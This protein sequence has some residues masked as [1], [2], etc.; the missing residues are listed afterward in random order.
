MF[1]KIV[2]FFCFILQHLEYKL[3]IA[4]FSTGIIAL[5]SNYLVLVLPLLQKRMID[6]ITVSVFDIKIVVLL[7]L[8]GLFGVIISISEIII[9]NNLDISL[10]T[11]LQKDLLESA[12]RNNNKIIQAR[13]AGAY[14]V[15]VFGDSEQIGSLL[16]T[17]Y[18][19]I[20]LLCIVSVITL[21][22]TA[23]WT[24]VF[25]WVVIPTYIIML[26]ILYISNKIYKEKFKQVREMIFKLNPMVL[27]YLENKKT[28]LGY[29][30]ISNY[31][32]QL[33]S[34]FEIRNK[35]IKSAARANTFGR[36]ALE[37]T[38]TISMIIFF[39]LSMQEILNNRMELSSFIAMIAYFPIVFSPIIA[40]QNISAGMNR[41]NTLHE[42]IKD[43]LGGDL[44]F[45]IPQQST[46]QLKN[47]TFSYIDNETS[48]NN[49]MNNFSLDVNKK[50][51][52]VGVSGEGKTTIIKILTGEFEAN[53]GCCLLGGEQVQNIPKSLIYSYIRIYG[54][55][56]EIFDN[57]LEYNITLGKKSLTK[58]EYIKKKIS[59]VESIENCFSKMI[60]SKKLILDNM[61]KDILKNLFLLNDKD[62]KN[63][64]VLI[65]IQEE[66]KRY[67][68]NSIE[69]LASIL[70]SKNH[71]IQ[72]KYDEILEKLEIN[73]L[74]DRDLGQRGMN[75]S[76]GEKN[77]ISLARFLLPDYK[78]F[79]VLD[80]PF[81]S[82]DILSE[83]K[84]IDILKQ[85]LKEE[86]GIIISHKINV[87]RD[88]SDEI[89]VLESGS[90][91]QRGDHETLI[92]E[93][94]LYKRIFQAYLSNRKN[95]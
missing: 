63:E 6:L 61:E 34:T 65:K 66:I 36:S 59:L 89:L 41:F 55:E 10:Q 93:N 76:G 35:Y 33:Y 12:I 50:I 57:T 42:K 54:Q 92:Q 29:A 53:K 62:I 32:N 23:Q 7:L 8:V 49:T 25:L 70:L 71:Y 46:V 81:T 16:N 83:Q 17:N 11:S 95:A 60:N 48:V 64:K 24:W 77:K 79:F 72:E 27:E 40:L 85:Y 28:I 74:K 51:G 18:F 13:G 84:C 90:I 14:M 43:N 82:L 75:I 26:L 94:G 3:K 15:N 47:C 56:P 58:Q 91:T 9:L 88:I 39:I 73:Y 38:K 1:K 4:F 68:T 87:I 45:A 52:I 30:D 67:G 86:N 44:K 37:T 78:G 19:S 31:E 2:N 69:E 20:V 21:I 80:E 5:I 22:I